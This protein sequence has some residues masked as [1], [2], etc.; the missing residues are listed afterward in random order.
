MYSTARRFYKPGTLTPKLSLE[1]YLSESTD[2]VGA[3]LA[4]L[5]PSDRAELEAKFAKNVANDDIEESSSDS[6][7]ESEDGDGSEYDD[8]FISGLAESIRNNSEVT[9][10]DNFMISSGDHSRIQNRKLHVKG[11]DLRPAFG[12]SWCGVGKMGE[13]CPI[14]KAFEDNGWSLRLYTANKQYMD[15]SKQR[16]VGVKQFL[17][18]TTD[19]VCKAIETLSR[20]DRSVLKAK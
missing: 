3:A 13:A 6:D 9:L 20:A 16:V 18:G 5:S 12:C 17:S 8:A 19:M 7:E 2:L 11:K 14:C 15:P 4:S 10:K 1:K